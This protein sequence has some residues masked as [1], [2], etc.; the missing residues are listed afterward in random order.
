MSNHNTPVNSFPKGNQH[1]KLAS[2][3]GR[4]KLFDTPV[5][6]WLA[7]CDYFNWCV[8]N[9]LPSE[10]VYGRNAKIIIVPKMRAMSMQALSIHIGVCNLKYYNKQAEFS[11]IVQYIK[12][13]IYA[14]NFEGAAA[15]LLNACIIAR[16]LG[17]SKQ[18]A[19]VGMS[20]KGMIY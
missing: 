20:A 4:P 6:L 9:P 15:G 7:A 2:F 3:A 11:P 12:T 10:G 14:Y 5:D 16:T 17:L 8:N 1:Y 13:V 19:N 18:S